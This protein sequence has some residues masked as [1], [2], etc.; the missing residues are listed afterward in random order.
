MKKK[1]ILSI[2]VFLIVLVTVVVFSNG[3]GKG[4]DLSALYPGTT[5]TPT[6]S[7]VMSRADWVSHAMTVKELVLES[8]LIVR[9]RVSG[10]PIT[11]VLRHELPVWD[12]NNK[13]VGSKVVSEMLFSDTTF[14][15]IK[16][17]LGKP[18]LN[19][20]VMQTGGFNQKLNRVEEVIDDPLYNVREEY[21]LFLVD[22]SGDA[23]QAPG[24]EL[25]V[26]VNPYGRFLI[27][28][29]N[30]SIFGENTSASVHAI[31]A[32]ADLE[33]QIEQAVQ[34]VNK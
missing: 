23:V 6:A 25:Y 31:S 14:E 3:I 12:E 34:G 30:L 21:I 32:V 13:I 18:G 7:R 24:R 15:I 1:L 19:I 20:T 16:T 28:K 4:K 5:I 11:R 2:S 22:I 9:A 8:D 27:D 26:A 17:Y 33:S 10:A 29:E